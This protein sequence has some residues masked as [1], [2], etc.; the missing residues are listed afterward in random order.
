M[1]VACAMALASGSDIWQ[2]S[3]LGSLAAGVQV[4][5]VG[6]IPIK[7]EDLIKEIY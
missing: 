5:R 4:S 6:N 7:D 1:L 2:A 3:F